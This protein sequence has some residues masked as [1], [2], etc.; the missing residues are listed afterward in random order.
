MRRQYTSMLSKEINCGGDKTR[1]AP[2]LGKRYHGYHV[3]NMAAWPKR[4]EVVYR[5]NISLKE[6]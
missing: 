3:N 1:R 2:P 6:I 5:Q 4:S